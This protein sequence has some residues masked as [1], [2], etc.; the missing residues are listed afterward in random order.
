VHPEWMSNYLAA[1][2]VDYRRPRIE[3]LFQTT[4]RYEYLFGKEAYRDQNW[5][6]E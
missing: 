3:E 4:L 6:D 5:P 2:D 1:P